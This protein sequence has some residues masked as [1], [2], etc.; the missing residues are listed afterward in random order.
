MV[1]NHFPSTFGHSAPWLI[2][3]IISLGTAGVKHYLNL[4]KKA[5]ER[6][7]IARISDPSIAA[8]FISAPKIL[9]LQNVMK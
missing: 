2:L 4:R 3:A 8:A 6:M 5:I 7:D 1:S 9:A